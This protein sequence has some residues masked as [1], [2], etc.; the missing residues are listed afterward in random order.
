MGP[1]ANRRAVTLLA[2]VAA[3]V[4]IACNGWLVVATLGTGLGV[5]A[6]VSVAALGAAGLALLGY[7]A[8]VPLRLRALDEMS[9]HRASAHARSAQYQPL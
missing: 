8:I 7:V 9:S 6:F 5:A 1:Y 4:I 2:A 3:A